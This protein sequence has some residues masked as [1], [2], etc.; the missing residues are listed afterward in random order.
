MRTPP[1]PIQL[2]LFIFMLILLFMLVQ[3]GLLHIAAEKLGIDFSKALLALFLCLLGSV[4]NIPLFTMPLAPDIVPPPYRGWLLGPTR[5]RP[6]RVIVAINLGGAIMPIL[7]SLYLVTRL[8]LGIIPVVLASAIVSIIS[9]FLSRPIPGLGIAMPIF[10]PPMVAAVCAF[11]FA[12][13][14]SA[15]VAYICSG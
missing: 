5:P 4:I 12:P 3:I 1:S 6:D 8:E 9:Y 13:N 11:I 10:I 2:I 7:F 14:H 15:A